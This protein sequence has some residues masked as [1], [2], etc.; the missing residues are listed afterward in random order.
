M[1][2]EGGS[3]RAEP[4]WPEPGDSL[5]ARGEEWETLASLLPDDLLGYAMSYKEAAD[6]LVENIERTGRGADSMVY[7][8]LFLY[9]HYVELMLKGLIGMGKTFQGQKPDY[10]KSHLIDVLWRKCRPILESAFPEGDRR[11]DEAVERCMKELAQV[12][13]KGEA[14]RYP[15]DQHQQPISHAVPCLGLRNIRDVMERIGGYLEGSYDGLRELLQA[16]SDLD[17]EHES[18]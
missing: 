11:D 2:T 9:R 6:A 3:D 5:F 10:P 14:F 15:E 7:P 13:P 17:S 12:D 16:Q 8:V 1:S 18:I 4:A